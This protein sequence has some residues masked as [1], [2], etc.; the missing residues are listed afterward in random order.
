MAYKN[1]FTPSTLVKYEGN[2]TEYPFFNLS[3]QDKSK[4]ISKKYNFGEGRTLTVENLHGIPTAF[5]AD[6][7]VALSY[8][9]TQKNCL[10]KK[11]HFT[12]KELSRLIGCTDKQRVKNSIRCLTGTSYTAQ[13]TILTKVNDKTIYLDETMMFHI[14]E[15]SRY[16][17]TK[18]K[19]SYDNEDIREKTWVKFNEYFVNNF[20]ANYVQYLDIGIYLKIKTPTAKRLYIYLEKK[21]GK[22]TSFTIG[23]EK[24]A[25]VIPIED[26]NIYNV[27]RVLKD[28][29]NI[30]IKHELIERYS[31]DNENI[32]FY[33]PLQLK[34][35]QS[36][37]DKEEANKK[38]YDE[39]Y[40]Y[41]SQL[42][43]PVYAYPA[44]AK[45]QVQFKCPYFKKLDEFIEY[46]GAYRVLEKLAYGI[47]NHI[48]NKPI[49]NLGGWLRKA[50]EENYPTPESFY[51]FIHR[52]DEA[53]EFIPEE[54]FQI[55]SQKIKTF[56]LAN[57]ININVLDK[58]INEDGEDYLEYAI[59]QC[60]QAKNIKNISGFFINSLKTKAFLDGYKF[61][62]KIKEEETDKKAKEIEDKHLVKL[63][64]LYDFEE[65]SS[66]K[67]YLKEHS[68]K[69]FE[70]IDKYRENFAVKMVIIKYG[71]K[72][73]EKFL[74]SRAL[75]SLFSE[76][77][78]SLE[79][80]Y[81]PSF[82]DWKNDPT[83]K[84][85]IE[86]YIKEVNFHSIYKT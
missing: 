10:D 44:F 55:K 78:K 50:V 39:I 56:C 75:T 4:C 35:I 73:L 76:D 70:L 15:Y 3:K 27:R 36:S 9:G 40:S 63:S 74:K 46:Y 26:K 57:K 58:Y 34:K 67:K 64:R 22:K 18:N 51:S 17:D 6:V 16:V 14:I 5:D 52:I 84:E 86:E 38:Y 7:L 53:Q 60:N 13:G 31:L 49:Q 77:L 30:L 81:F 25:A 43:N 45:Q 79:N 82:E 42:I 65:H 71:E 37:E 85:K 72:D 11:I 32:T 54:S 48:F 2:I 80:Y 83:N 47:Y 21:I 68:D 59:E 62:R 1:G 24:L 28:A 33:F 8:L 29:G 20:I 61:L 12:I 41:L 23:I 66:I 19:K 69:A